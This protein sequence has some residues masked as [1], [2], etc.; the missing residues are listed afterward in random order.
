VNT[1]S[2][3]IKGDLTQYPENSPAR[4]TLIKTFTQQ[5][6]EAIDVLPS[7]VKILSVSS[8]SIKIAFTVPDLTVAELT[9]LI[10]ND[11]T[12]VLASKVQG[13]ISLSL[14]PMFFSFSLD[15]TAFDI[16]WNRDFTKGGPAGETRAG[17]PYYPPKGWF[18]YGLAV[19]GKF[20][21]EKWLT[22]NGS[23]GE[24]AVAYHGTSASN[25]KTISD[26][27]FYLEKVT[28]FGTGIYC[29]PMVDEAEKYCTSPGST[30]DVFEID[31][32]EGKVKFKLAFMCRVN[33]VNIQQQTPV[34]WTVPSADDIRPYGVLLK[35]V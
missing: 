5:T 18:R 9:N 25:C 1:F 24:W 34:V 10:T 20:S 13:Y 29:S 15:E 26:L 17:F 11:S 19:V 4:E 16:E 2:L 30:G 8:G 21:D 7:R 28:Q 35:R 23:F 33:P 22:Y 12:G 14:H 31:T 3:R 27:K 32:N 6:A